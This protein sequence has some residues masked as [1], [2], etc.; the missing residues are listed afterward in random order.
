[1]TET[2]ERALSLGRLLRLNQA[3]YERF[4][5]DYCSVWCAIAAQ[6]A[7]EF[8]LDND[9]EETLLAAIHARLWSDFFDVMRARSPLAVARRAA[10]S[11]AR[12]EALQL[13]PDEQRVRL[14][15]RKRAKRRKSPSSARPSAAN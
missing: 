6:V 14:L 13:L 7:Q 3:S 4:L 12:E 5:H 2:A 10:L 8:G 1:M 9:Q 11:A 15:D